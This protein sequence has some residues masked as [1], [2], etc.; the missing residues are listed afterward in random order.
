MTKQC[1]EPPYSFSKWH[2]SIMKP[3]SC[4]V[5]PVAD[6]YRVRRLDPEIDSALRQVYGPEQYKAY[7]DPLGAK[8][9]KEQVAEA[10][11]QTAFPNNQTGP[12]GPLRPDE[13]A[14]IRLLQRYWTLSNQVNRFNGPAR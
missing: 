5:V 12:I 8:A 9:I 3:T 2:M 10:G 14:Q 4:F 13:L 1:N 11:I 6:Y 7:F